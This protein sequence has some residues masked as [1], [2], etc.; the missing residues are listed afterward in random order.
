MVGPMLHQ[1]LYNN[2]HCGSVP[3]LLSH[4]SMGK[5]NNVWKFV[6]KTNCTKG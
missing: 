6:H 3:G 2:R 4:I 1:I 5:L